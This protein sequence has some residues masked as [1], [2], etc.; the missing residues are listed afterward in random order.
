M[1][2]RARATLHKLGA[3]LKPASSSQRSAAKRRFAGGSTGMPSWGKYWLSILNVHDW[4][5]VNP[6]PAELWLLPDFLPFHPHRWWIHTRNV[7][8]PMGYLSG[9]RFKA[10]LNPLLRSL[11]QVSRASRTLRG[12]DLTPFPPRNFTS[13]LTSRS[14][15]RPVE[16]MYPPP[17][18]T[19]PTQQ[20][21]TPS[22][23]SSMSTSPSPRVSSGKLRWLERIVS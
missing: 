16:T 12:V 19:L 22:S 6:T 18:F 13:S 10:E 7:Y 9:R 1:M 5:G 11:R 21:P 23:R 2:V 3:S 15:G 4:K 20:W 8:I 17:I 14:A